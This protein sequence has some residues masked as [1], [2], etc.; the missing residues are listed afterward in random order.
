MHS[1]GAPDQA[2][3]PQ[4]QTATGP[5]QQSPP[6]TGTTH[7]QD[8]QRQLHAN[9]QARVIAGDMHPQVLKMEQVFLPHCQPLLSVLQ[10]L[11]NAFV[12]FDVVIIA[13][14][15]ALHILHSTSQHPRS[16]GG[17]AEQLEGVQ[18]EA[19]QQGLQVGRLAGAACS[20]L[21]QHLRW[22]TAA[23]HWHGHKRQ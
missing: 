23:Q 14:Q 2:V 17:A 22:A 10:L 13:A 16:V 11:L 6:T 15:P 8:G 7:L 1:D 21:Q 18:Q 19:D 5:P 9:G 4:G 3:H 20:T 12:E